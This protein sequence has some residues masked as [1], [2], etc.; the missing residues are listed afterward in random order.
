MT[1]PDTA[2]DRLRMLLNSID[3]HRPEMTIPRGLEEAIKRAGA[4]IHLTGTQERE[5]VTGSLSASDKNF[6][7]K[8][9]FRGD[10]RDENGNL[11][12]LKEHRHALPPA[13][14]PERDGMR[15][16]LA[17]PLVVAWNSYVRL[18]DEPPHGTEKQMRALARL[19]PNCPAL[20]PPDDSAALSRAESKSPQ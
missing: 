9:L 19:I 15:E 18:F 1:H 6:N 5:A 16:A 20:D 2:L 10:D 17:A 12:T 4:P 7:P 8:L 3:Y 13:P 14:M 11:T